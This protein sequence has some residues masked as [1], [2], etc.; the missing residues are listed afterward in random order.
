MYFK[1]HG[2]ISQIEYGDIDVPK[3][4]PNEILI[5][6]AYGALNHLDLF[7]LKGWPGL[8]LEMPHAIG[9]DGAGVVEEVGSQVNGFKKGDRVLVNPGIG[10]GRCIQCYSGQQNFCSQFSILGEHIQGTAAEFFKIP[11]ENAVKIPD[12]LSFEIAAAAP[13]TFLTAWRCLVTQGNIKPGEYVLIQGAG[14]GLAT[15]AIQ[16]AKLFNAI[17]IATTGTDEKVEKTKKLGADYVI[18][19]NTNKDYKKYVFTELT[20]RHGIDLALDSV[21]QSTFPT[22]LSLLRQGG[23]IVIPGA[24]TGPK[25]ELDL[26]Q[27]FW[28]QLK[29]IGSTMSNHAEFHEVIQHVINGKLK[30]IID[31]IFPLTEGKNA[32]EHLNSANQFGKVLLKP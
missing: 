32:M 11:Q 26:R 25:A 16:I 15:A 1:Q 6:T 17:V 13:L 12:S 20:K 10:C 28:K 30:P 19:Y 4:D 24:T 8:N 14:G 27:V 7:V 23:R 9:S 29:I 5:K 18:N 21:G 22:S 3:I 2:D 31:K